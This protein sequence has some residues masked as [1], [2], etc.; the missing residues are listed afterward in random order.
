MSESTP[1]SSWRA[2]QPW[3]DTVRHDELVLAAAREPS[4]P[5]LR[6]AA[7]EPRSPSAAVSAAAGFRPVELALARVLG[8][9]W[10]DRYISE[11]GRVELEISGDDLIAAG[12]SEGPA[13]G[14]GLEAALRAKLDGETSGRD[15][16]LRLALDVAQAR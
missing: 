6:L 11:W 2:S 1:R 9:T 12:V 15:D 14:R 4:A 5:V 10:L 8:A 7:G 13:I 3:A 16:E